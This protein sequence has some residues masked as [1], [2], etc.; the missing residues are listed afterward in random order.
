MKRNARNL[1]GWAVLM[2]ALT[3][4]SLA[5]D[6]AYHVSASIPFNFAV[7]GQQLPAGTYYL[8]VNYQT[9][10]VSL[11]N[12]ET[13]RSWAVVARPDDGNHFTQAVLDFV[14][15]NGGRVL[16]DLKTPSAGVSFSQA[17][18]LVASQRGTPVVVAMLR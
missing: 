10:V 9:H 14:T 2:I 12:K 7:E 8:D 6:S 4:L 3:G 16:A 15:I 11:R 13:G 18:S 1:V 17:K 5:Q